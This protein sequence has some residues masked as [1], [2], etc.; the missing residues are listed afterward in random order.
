MK[1][2]PESKRRDRNR[3]SGYGWFPGADALPGGWYPPALP[4]ILA[5]A[6]ILRIAALFSLSKSIYFDFMLW[7]EVVYHDWAQK[8]LAG[9]F[10]TTSYCGFAP[11]PAYITALVYKIFST[12]ILYIRF[13]NI[14]LGTLTCWMVYLAGREMFNHRTGLT[15][16]LLA[17]LYKP[18]IFYSIVPMKTAL[19]VFLFAVIIYLFSAILNRYSAIKT[20]LLGL[21]A[22]LLLNVR[23]NIALIIPVLPIFILLNLRKG[24]FPVK[25]FISVPA[26]YA[27]GIIAAVSPFTI[28]GY[29]VSEDV[30]F[31]TPQTGFALYLGNNLNN[32]DPYFRPVQFA[33]SSPYEQGVQLIIEAS[34]RV[35]R[36]LTTTEAASY[37]TDE[38]VGM[39]L[40]KPFALSWKIIQKIL[41][42]FNRFEP[43]DHYNIDFLSRSVSFFKLPF[44]GFGLI[45]P[46][47]MAGIFI[48]T[49]NSRKLLYICLVTV[50]YG[51]T[52]VLFFMSAR[53][54]VPILVVLIPFA[55]AGISETV[56]RLRN[57]K[58]A[59]IGIY[60]A[61]AV[62]FLIV[63]FLPIRATDDL[64]AYYN[65][66]AMI[67]NSKGFEDEAV[68]YWKES[69]LMN[70]QFSAFA[71]ISLAGKCYEKGDVKKA[72]QYLESIDD[73]SYAAA[74]K[75]EKIGDLMLD[76]NQ[77]DNAKI[78][79]EKSLEINAG[80]PR[81]RRKLVEIYYDIDK[82][83]A[84]REYKALQYITSF[85]ESRDI[86]PG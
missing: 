2:A 32:P 16:C 33:F 21:S 77:V 48:L 28:R 75:Y 47:A 81:T 79:Y 82:D 46:L 19:S 9:T 54:R 14:I 53:F 36:T 11:L 7:D 41:V 55:A 22:G 71:D 23:P 57:R 66:H 56:S 18:F 5:L 20:L 80:V 64:S 86:P 10:K 13:M 31:T 69:S 70:K 76:L 78:A 42:M 52:M 38:T 83:R 1:Q 6:L 30:G 50:L 40:E 43:G 44:I 68:R 49:A 25:G 84:L 17:S 72:L 26:L 74:I 51:S 4:S 67:L 85:Y 24:K 63:E 3:N 45:L 62:L 37:W 15:A 73:D 60:T 8:I 27:A 59:E 35:E 58:F 12:K 61:I 34:R 65:T 29:M 39:A